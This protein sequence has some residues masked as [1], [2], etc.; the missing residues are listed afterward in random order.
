MRAANIN[1]IM[2]NFRYQTK[3]FFAL[4]AFANAATLSLRAESIAIPN[5]SFELPLTVY[6][7]QRV[8]SWQETPK[9]FWYNEVTMGPWDQLVGVF[10]NTSPTNS[11]HIDNCDGSQ[12]LFLFAVPGT[13]IF[14]DYDTM[15]WSH[16]TPPHDFNVAFEP[17]KSYTLTAGFIGGGGGMTN[18]V[19][20]E[21][22]LY[23][24]DASS[25]QVTV[26]ATNIVYSSTV[27]SNQTHFIDGQLTL[28][29]VKPSDAWVG[30]KLG[31]QFL[32]TVDFAS[33]G[34]YWDIDNVRLTSVLNPV[35]I[36]PALVNGHFQ[37]T[38]QSDP[39]LRFDILRTANVSLPSTNW[40]A[41]ATVT[42]SSG[43]ISFTDPTPATGLNFYQAR[44]L[45]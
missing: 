45:P 32:S 38:L 13:G 1:A 44:Q 2:N 34:G 19:S 17:G 35:L 24:R 14:Q 18:G 11:D 21:M 25:N 22:S 36:N 31:V 26:A 10:L 12:A 7:D 3:L 15:D 4:F 40:P 9:P 43:T 6:A 30:K 23:Y 8:D 33:A 5:A 16:V 41:I 28:P 37:M 20:V 39:G 27:F 29:A 42:N